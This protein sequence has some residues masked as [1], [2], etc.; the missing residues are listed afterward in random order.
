MTAAAVF[1]C[2]WIG[3]SPDNDGRTQICGRPARGHVIGANGRRISI[4]AQHVG[5]AKGQS[6]S[7]R[8][9]HSTAPDDRSHPSTYHASTVRFP[10]DVQVVGTTY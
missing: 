9:Q 8:F 2:E 6:A 1:R 5:W 3:T 4:C 10:G 7:G